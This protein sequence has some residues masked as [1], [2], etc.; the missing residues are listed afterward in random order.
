MFSAS[1]IEYLY[2]HSGEG[3][4][5]FSKKLTELLV[6]SERYRWFLFHVNTVSLS[7]ALVTAVYAS[8]LVF[9]FE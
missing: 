6:S 3:V 5:G 8:R 7:A 2:V 9:S 1:V 4:H